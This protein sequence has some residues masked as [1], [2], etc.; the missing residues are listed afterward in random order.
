MATRKGSGRNG[1]AKT[2]LEE[3]VRESV[4]AALVTR[5]RLHA[6]QQGDELARE[7]LKDD[8]FREEFVALARAVAREALEALRARRG[9]HT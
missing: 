1:K 3:L 9:E 2:V 5:L 8:T 4:Q 6:E 7:I